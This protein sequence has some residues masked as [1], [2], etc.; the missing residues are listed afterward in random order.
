[1]AV[2]IAIGADVHNDVVDVGTAA[3]S[4]KQLIAACSRLQGDVD[5]FHTARIAPRTV[6][7]VQL[8]IS[9]DR[10]LRTAGKPQHRSECRRAASDRIFARAC[11]RSRR[12]V[13]VEPKASDRAL[14]LRRVLVG[15]DE[16][17]KSGGDGSVRVSRG[18]TAAA[19][20][21]Q[22]AAISSPSLAEF[23]I[24]RSLQPPNLFFEGAD[25]DHLPDAGGNSKEETVASDIE[26]AGGNDCAYRPRASCPR[27]GEV[28]PDTRRAFVRG[29]ERTRRE[30]R[31]PLRGSNVTCVLWQ[32][33]A[34]R[35]NRI[36]RNPDIGTTVPDRP[37]AARLR[38]RWRQVP[39]RLQSRSPNAQVGD[40]GVAVLEIEAFQK[41]TGI[42][43]A[44]PFNGIANGIRRP[45]VARQRVSKLL[46][47]HRGE[48]QDTTHGEKSLRVSR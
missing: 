43:R 32:T 31:L 38:S 46:R 10:S 29:R 14:G 8:A 27:G 15:I 3:E 25:A 45:A 39:K 7:L 19:G 13:L 28:S 47:R 48:R 35:H 9:D 21:A 6:S 18:P 23:L 36:A 24:G 2:H 20:S 42:V 11:R 16:F 26:S 41:L 37:K 40:G 5:N 34:A 44:N 33:P 1:M 12:E 30:A 4:A 22:R 17:G